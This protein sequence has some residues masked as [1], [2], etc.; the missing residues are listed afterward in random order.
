ME[1]KSYDLQ[2]KVSDID[3]SQYFTGRIINQ[4][5]QKSK[6]VKLLLK[7]V[8]YKGRFN[9]YKCRIK[10]LAHIQKDVNSCKL[11]Q[12]DIIV[13]MTNIRKPCG[14]ENPYQFNYKRYLY[15]KGIARESY[16]RSGTWEIIGHGK[17]LMI[18]SSQLRNKLLRLYKRYGF[19]NDEFAVLSALTLGF[20]D[21]LRPETKRSFV[22]A[23]VMHTLAVSGLH[24]G[25]VFYVLNII[26]GFLSENRYGKIIK[27]ILVI[28]L[29][30]FY[31]LLTGASISVIRASAMFSLIQIG[32]SIKRTINIYNILA[33][34]AFFLFLFNPFQVFDVGF[35]LSF[36]AVLSIVFFQPR[37]YRILTF[38]NR[39]IDR[40]W[41]LFTVSIAAQIGTFP[42]V[43]YYFHNFPLYFWITNILILPP[44]AIVIYLAL[45]L[46]IFSPL[47][48]AAFV[49]A[50]FLD[51]VLMLI[52]NFVN[53]V[54]KFPSSL[55]EGLYNSLAETILLYAIIISVSVFILFK[56]R[57]SL[58]VCQIFIICFLSFKMLRKYSIYKQKE[59]VI[60][61][62]NKYSVVNL[63]D[64]KK[65]YLITDLNTEGINEKLPDPVKDYWLRR[66]VYDVSRIFNI[67]ELTGNEKACNE[68]GGIYY[69]NIGGNPILN[70]KGK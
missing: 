33:A 46:F 36:L 38:R 63:I 16:I 19:K 2:R 13:A 37:F 21:D 26:F 55:I 44:V 25:I 8:G 50:G 51:I 69:G 23:G 68:D 15:Y 10:I 53:T 60:F 29:L 22:S 30:W 56:K 32:N 42:V 57:I 12:G 5:Q 54:K 52:N 47:N 67:S 58:I 27:L 70:F 7:S 59:I 45:L 20:R 62:V 64:G 4:P 61:N 34:L 17:S 35:Q 43:I 1:L 14:P 39:I 65:N 31:A 11:E 9:W 24:T 48:K 40:V 66:G 6:T 41:M 28:L 3:E 49:I 18:Y